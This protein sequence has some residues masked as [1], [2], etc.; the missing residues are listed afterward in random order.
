MEQAPNAV[1]MLVLAIAGYLCCPITGW[2][3]FFMAKG[4]MLQYPN[5]GMTKAAYW[6]GLICL[7]LSAISIVGYGAVICLGVAGGALG[8]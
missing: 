8:N 2:V 4:A 3:A 6:L 7:I 1:V 5:C